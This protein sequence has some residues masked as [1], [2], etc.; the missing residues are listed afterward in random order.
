MVLMIWTLT[1][2]EWEK[3]VKKE[4]IDDDNRNWAHHSRDY[5]EMLD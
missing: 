5:F 1:L 2:S 3:K 4:A